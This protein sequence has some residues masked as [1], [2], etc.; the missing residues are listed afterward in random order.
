MFRTLHG[1]WC[2]PPAS[3]GLWE[4]LMGRAQGCL[5]ISEVVWMFPGLTGKPLLICLHLCGAAEWLYPLANLLQEEPHPCHGAAAE[6][7][8]LH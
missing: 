7:G 4:L 6:D 5:L 3:S 8:G 2:V 1:A